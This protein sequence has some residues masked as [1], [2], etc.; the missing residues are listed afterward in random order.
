VLLLLL[1]KAIKNDQE[2]FDP[3]QGNIVDS[4]S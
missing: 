4:R 3:V 2:W 1:L